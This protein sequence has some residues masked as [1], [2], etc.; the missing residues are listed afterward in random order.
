MTSISSPVDQKVYNWDL[1]WDTRW[2]P[3]WEAIDNHD[4][5]SSQR[6]HSPPLLSPLREPQREVIEQIFKEIGD[7]NG[8]RQAKRNLPEEP[9]P[10]RSGKIRRIHGILAETSL[11]KATK[12]N[13]TNQ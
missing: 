3:L 6:I 11:Q 8:S 2:K 12:M 4:V 13:A 10:L 1:E 5:L 9:L 7:Q